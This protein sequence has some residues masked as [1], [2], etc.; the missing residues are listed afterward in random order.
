MKRIAL[1]AMAALLLAGCFYVADI[2]AQASAAAR[3]SDFDRPI[4]DY[5][6]QIKGWE[7]EARIQ[8]VL[9]GAVFVFG[10]LVSPFQIRA[11]QWGKTA[12]IVLGIAITLITGVKSQLFSA[13]Y[14]TLHLAAADGRAITAQLWPMAGMLN[15]PH[16]SD[17]I[18]K[19]TQKLYFKKL[20]EFPAVIARLEGTKTAATHNPDGGLFSLPRVYAQSQQQQSGAPLPRWVQKPPADDY[21]LFFVGRAVDASLA[22]AKTKSL[23]D[24]YSRAIQRLKTRVPNASEADLLALIKPSAIVQDYAFTY[25][26][27]ARGFVYYTLLRLAKE[28][29]TIGVKSLSTASVQPTTFKRRNWRPATSR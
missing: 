20:A 21:S 26:N 4:L 3:T 11:S 15:N 1:L 19:T 23:D 14:R 22:D 9:V 16:T 27:N 29:E 5:E 24:A 2:H 12:T 17:E 28:I 13:D 18:R 6:N 25:D 8:I 10:A 7:R